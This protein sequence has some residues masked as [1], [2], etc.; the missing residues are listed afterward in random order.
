VSLNADGFA[1]DPWLYLYRWSRLFPVGVQENG[2]DIVEPAFSARSSNDAIA[3]EKFLNLSFGAAIDFTKNW[4]LQADYAFSNR[5]NSDFSSVPY[6][7]AKSHWFGVQNRVDENGNQIFVDDEGNVVTSGGMPA[8]EFPM[9]DH[10]TRDNTYVSQSTRRAERHT[11]NAYS[12]YNLDLAA[13][14]NLKLM[15]GTNITAY[16]WRNHTSRRRNLMNGDNPQFNFATGAETAGGNFDWD[17]QAGFFG[18]F[19]YAF[20]DKYLFEANLRRDGTSKFPMH[21]QWQWYPSLSAGWVLSNESFMEALRPVVSFAKF[22]T[23]WGS[24]GDQNV[25]NSLYLPRMAIGKNTWLT[26]NGEQVFQLSTPPPVTGNMEWQRI[27]HVN[28]GADLRFFDNRLGLT[29]EWYRR[30]TLNM[31]IPGDALPDTYGAAAPQGNYGDL[32]TKGWEIALDYTHRFDS[33]L[34]LSANANIA[35][36]VTHITKA[37]DWNTPWEERSLGTTFSTGRRYGDVYGFVTDRLFQKEDFVYDANGDFVQTTIVRDGVAKRTNVLSGDNP[38]YQVYFEDG[39]QTLLISPGDVKFADLNGDGYIDIGKGT[40]GDPGDRTVIGNTTPRYEYG[41]RMGADYKGFDL[42][43]FVQGIGQRSIWG[44]GQLAIPGFHIKDGAMPQAIAGDY[45]REDRTDAFY[46]RAWHLNGANQGFVMRPQSRYM[47]DMAY[48]RV[49]NITVG[50]AVRP[51]VLRRARLGSFRLF[52]SLENMFTFD[53]L[54]G[55]PIDPEA[56]SGA[57]ILRP[58]GNYNLGRTGTSTPVFRSASMGIQIGF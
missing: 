27:E 20:R 54:R 1:A 33:G 46:P 3:N 15:L 47:L 31:I 4:N 18:R 36:V 22:R 32:R 16:E 2:Q 25:P 55:L 39:N 35:D 5:A 29:G 26:A 24:I 50:Y 51:E 45:W 40:N 48:L 17:A 58:G 49:K 7:Q 41:L 19:N 21:L 30:N 9:A 52:V 13:G 53:K 6:V 28:I 43:V 14:H 56:I 44:A 23:S 10:T 38:V 57:S 8:Y 37:A 12:T 34:R 42:S 11:F